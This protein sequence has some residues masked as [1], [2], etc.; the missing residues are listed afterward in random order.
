MTVVM[1][2]RNVITG[3]IPRMTITATAAE[4]H[5]EVVETRAT[6]TVVDIEAMAA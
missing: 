4:D 2:D 3:T 5:P 6:I 1:I